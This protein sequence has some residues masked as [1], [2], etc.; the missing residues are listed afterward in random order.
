M[1][2]KSF[3]E[4]RVSKSFYFEGKSFKEE[5]VSKSFYFKGKSFKEER[6]SISRERVSKRVSGK[7]LSFEGKS[8]K[9]KEFRRVSILRERKSCKDSFR[10]E[11]QR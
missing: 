1:Q 9:E 11:F 3:E 2:R 6:V 4:E 10:K 8:F 7:S 5:R